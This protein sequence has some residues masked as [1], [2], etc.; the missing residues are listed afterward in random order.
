MEKEVVFTNDSALQKTYERFFYYGLENEENFLKTLIYLI[1]EDLIPE[2]NKIVEI[3]RILDEQIQLLDKEQ[4]ID[5]NR[6]AQVKDFFIKIEDS[7]TMKMI[8]DKLGELTKS[9]QTN[10]TQKYTDK[11]KAEKREK[12]KENIKNLKIFLSNF[13][14]KKLEE[15]F[16]AICEQY[17]KFITFSDNGKEFAKDKIERN[18]VGQFRLEKGKIRFDDRDKN[19]NLIDILANNKEWVAYVYKMLKI[20]RQMSNSNDARIQIE[21]QSK[22]LEAIVAREGYLGQS[23]TDAALIQLRKYDLLEKIIAKEEENLHEDKVLKGLTDIQVN[24]IRQLR[25]S[26]LSEKL[27]INQN[28]KEEDKKD[29]SKLRTI[30]EIQNFDTYFKD[31]GTMPED[32]FM[33]EIIYSIVEDMNVALSKKSEDIKKLGISEEGMY[34]YIVDEVKR[35][36]NEYCIFLNIENYKDFNLKETLKGIEKGKQN[37][38]IFEITQF[39]LFRKVF[40]FGKDNSSSLDKEDKNKIF[41]Y[42][43]KR[44]KECIREEGLKFDSDKIQFLCKNQKHK[45]KGDLYKTLCQLRYLDLR[46][47]DINS[48]YGDWKKYVRYVMNSNYKMNNKATKAP[49]SVGSR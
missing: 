18:Q 29:F 16:T 6:L 25:K 38:S 7:K 2:Q 8:L 26:E 44:I 4:E 49:I 17:S 13:S 14:E 48:I 22:L 21:Y 15:E 35:N 37:I 23:T 42:I 43:E 19:N 39:L 32:E 5:Y 3:N 28:E 9:N 24:E 41:S 12:Q 10:N 11:E 45:H 31:K 46:S 36:I 40:F 27:K 47:G 33:K 1:N 30:L 34:Q 20:L